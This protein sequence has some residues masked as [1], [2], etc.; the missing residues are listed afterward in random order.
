M[1]TEQKNH[2]KSLMRKERRMQRLLV[3][4]LVVIGLPSGFFIILQVRESLNSDNPFVRERQTAD[5]SKK[6]SSTRQASSRVARSGSGSSSS[7]SGRTSSSIGGGASKSQPQLV[8]K[9]ELQQAKQEMKRLA[10][11]EAQQQS[12]HEQSQAPEAPR[13]KEAFEPRYTIET[14]DNPDEQAIPVVEQGPIKVGNGRLGRSLMGQSRLFAEILNQ[15][16]QAVTRVAIKVRFTDAQDR[17][18]TERILN[19]LAISSGVFGDTIKPL[20]GG[21]IRTFGTSVDD[22]PRRWNGGV[23]ISIEQIEQAAPTAPAGVTP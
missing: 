21:E 17:V 11:Q 12:M 22:L 3:I 13:E 8:S 18:V 23:N 5:W 1:A 7:G 20:R 19:P 16:E 2:L 15:S 14:P 9:Q 10:S 6:P 4:L